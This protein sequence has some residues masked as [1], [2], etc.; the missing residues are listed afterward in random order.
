MVRFPF[1]VAAHVMIMPHW[2]ELYS[3]SKQEASAEVLVCSRGG[4]GLLAERLQVVAELWA[5]NIKVESVCCIVNGE[6]IIL[7]RINSYL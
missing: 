5:A 7:N 4:S 2:M 6:I 1:L 3:C